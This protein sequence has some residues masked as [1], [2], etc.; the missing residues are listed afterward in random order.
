MCN[1]TLEA[2]TRLEGSQVMDDHYY[3]GGVIGMFSWI[4]LY[5]EILWLKSKDSPSLE[6]N[7]DLV[8][9]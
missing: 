5:D 6:M 8:M 1:C 4:T 2:S 3:E 9:S 7:Y